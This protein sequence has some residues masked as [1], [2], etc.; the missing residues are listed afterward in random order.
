[1]NGL[2]RDNPRCLHFDAVHG[3]VS[4][5]TLAVD[6]VAQTVNHAAQH[7]TARRNFHDRACPLY[8]VALFNAAVIAEDNHTYVVDFQVQGHA[9]YAVCELDHFARLDVVEAIDARHAVRYGQNL[10][11]LCNIGFSAEV[12]DL[13]LQDRRDFRSTNI[14]HSS[15]GLSHHPTIR[16][17]G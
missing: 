12:S 8:R 9:L 16:V 1:M 10:T 11:N 7:A 4:Q 17:K 15:F 14:H 6:R 13:I 3:H 5:W 2:T